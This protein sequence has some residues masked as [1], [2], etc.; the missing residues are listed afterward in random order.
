MFS[1]S[2]KKLQNDLKRTEGGVALLEK[3]RICQKLAL[4]QRG[5]I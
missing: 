4:L 1:F 3:S 5:S 2:G